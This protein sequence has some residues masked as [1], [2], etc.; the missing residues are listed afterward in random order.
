M[1]DVAVVFDMKTNTIGGLK[2]NK[3]RPREKQAKA[4]NK[5]SRGLKKNKRWP[6]KQK[7]KRLQ[8]KQLIFS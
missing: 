8:K 6:Q 1:S 2:K 3:R 7:A 4:S 5:T